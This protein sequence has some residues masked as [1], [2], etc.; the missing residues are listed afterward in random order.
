M[1]SSPDG[2]GDFDDAT[3]AAPFVTFDHAGARVIGLR[4]GT[5]V[6]YAVVQVARDGDPPLIASPVP[7]ERSATVTVGSPREFSAAT[8]GSA[9]WTIDGEAAGSGSSLTYAPTVAQVGGHTIEVVVGGETRRTWDVIVL[10][11]DDDEDGWTK[12]TDCD[13]TDPAAHP[14]RRPAA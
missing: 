5:A 7:A 8:S 9:V 10:D 14:T 4:A 12:T 1:T 3:G 6:S 2:D 11:R 13:E